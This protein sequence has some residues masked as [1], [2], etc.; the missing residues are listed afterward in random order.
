MSAATVRLSNC[1]LAYV[2]DTATHEARVRCSQIGIAWSLNAE[3]SH[4]RRTRAFYPHQRTQGDFS[5]QFQCKGWAEQRTLMNWFRAYAGVIMAAGT[6]NR[7]VVPPPMAVSV[8]SRKFLRLGFPTTGFTFG[9]HLGSM[10]FT[11]T[12]TFISVSDPADPR[13]SILT[14][15]QVSTTSFKDA[16]SQERDWFYPG[17]VNNHP[18]TLLDLIYAEQTPDLGSNPVVQ[19]PGV[20]PQ[21][22]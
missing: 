1:A 15:S 2:T 22:L 16:T 5:L 4:A 9:D 14:T 19:T 8:P 12:I 13:A 21:Y 17:S 20:G 3:E 10:L 6:A 11:P 7:R 18:Q